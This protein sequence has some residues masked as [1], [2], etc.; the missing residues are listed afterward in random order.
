M[1]RIDS[2]KRVRRTGAWVG[3]AALAT[4]SLGGCSAAAWSRGGMPEGASEES[5]IVQSLWNGTWVTALAVGILTWGLI[6]WCIIV[7]RRRRGDTSVPRQLRYNIPIEVLYTVAPIA[8]VGAL[9]FFTIRDASELT[10]V[11]NDQKE[12]IGVVGFRWSWTFNYL[13]QNVY[14]VGVPGD[15][16]L[17]TLYLPVNEKVKFKLASPDVIHSFW[18]PAFLFKMDVVP[19]RYNEFELTPNREGTFAGKCAELCG[20]DHSRMLF[21]V[22]VV[23][24]AEFDAHM[25]E[26]RA[27]GQVGVLDA[28]RVNDKAQ[29]VGGKDQS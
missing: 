15:T 6:I 28:G 4:L 21:N 20:V 13:D 8:V 29:V 2:A 7:Y 22:K 14:D 1:Q 17:P 26:L 9:L 12:T 23:P 10:T 19:G 3:I 25:A 11:K 16:N 18:V 27:K 5:S 24:Q